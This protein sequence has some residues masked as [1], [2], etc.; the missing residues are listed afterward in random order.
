M[1]NQAAMNLVHGLLCGKIGQL[2]QKL[3][4]SAANA[5]GIVL[6]TQDRRGRIGKGF[7]TDAEM[8]A[9]SRMELNR[10]AIAK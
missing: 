2:L 7:D 3:F 8:I 10:A 6:G 4:H 1:Q 5:L 9:A